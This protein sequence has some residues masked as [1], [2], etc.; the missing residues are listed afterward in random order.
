ME[1][2][3]PAPIRK[4][5]KPKVPVELTEGL[6]PIRTYPMRPD[7]DELHARALAE[8][9]ETIAHKMTAL[10]AH[11]G[12]A[13]GPDCWYQ[14]CLAM[15]EER[16]PGF[17]IKTGRKP[18]KW[19]GLVILMLAGEMKRELED[20]ASSQREAAEQLAA[21]EPWESFLAWGAHNI[22]DRDPAANLLH[23]YTHMADGLKR[24]GGEVYRFHA[25]QNTVAEWDDRVRDALAN[26]SPIPE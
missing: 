11:Y 20:G 14:L 25:L 2:K 16:Y 26:P 6:A 19:T 21:R 9:Q 10:R 3:R 18:E 7:C 8:R 1:R 13:D 5:F 4:S 24:V 23:Q 22:K 17:R 15:A 12:I